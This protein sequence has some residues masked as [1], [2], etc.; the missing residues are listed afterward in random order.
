MKA[1]Y[2]CDD[3]I[4]A[5]YS[6]LYI[7]W[8]E[9]RDNEVGIEF[10]TKVEHRLFSHYY[11]TVACERK[12]LLFEQFVQKHLG[13]QSY[14]DIYHALLADDAY[15]AEAVFKVL[16][17]ARHIKNQRHIMQHL[18]D[19]DVA[20][21]FEL[22]RQV[23][24]ESHLYSGFIRFRE[25]QNGVLYAE[26][27]PKSQ[28]LTCIGDFFANRFPMENWMIFDKTHEV[29]MV[30][31]KQKKWTL[32]E[33]YPLDP[34]LTEQVSDKQR[35]YEGLWQTFHQRIAIEERSNP[36]CQASHL[37]LRY[38][39]DMSEFQGQNQTCA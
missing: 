20:K 29:F 37:P 13:S 19:P 38:R 16:Q 4:T 7:A 36:R 30:H 35:L 22:S 6:A 33:G 9:N 5:I 15:K 12:S 14:W 25:L 3:N 10:R 17:A 21:V 8:K 28:V 26:I 34:Y 1:I 39:R 27:T 32:V 24:N 31:P 23:G 18:S 2:L 11:E